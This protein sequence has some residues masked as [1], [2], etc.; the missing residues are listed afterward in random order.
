[1]VGEK[2]RCAA[3]TGSFWSWATLA[4]P[5]SS[6]A[7]FYTVCP[8]SRL[9]LVAVPLFGS[10]H[11]LFCAWL[12]RPALPCWRWGL[13]VED[14]LISILLLQLSRIQAI[15]CGQRRKEDSRCHFII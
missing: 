4:P 14:N 11:T 10:T 13:W 5:L 7:L 3:Q 9:T 2:N 12:L 1:M 15:I 8:D 6:F